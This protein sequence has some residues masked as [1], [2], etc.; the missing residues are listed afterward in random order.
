M[1]PEELRAERKRRCLKQYEAARQSGVSKDT[2]NRWELGKTWPKGAILKL[3][4][5]WWRRAK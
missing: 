5:R 1:T 4:Q 2:W 3:L